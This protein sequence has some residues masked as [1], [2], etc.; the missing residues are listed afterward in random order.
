MG[1]RKLSGAKN[2]LWLGTKGVDVVGDGTTALAGVGYFKVTAKAASGSA[3]G[4]LNIND[5]FYNPESSTL[6]P[7]TGDVV[8]PFTLTKV[9]FVKDIPNSGSKQTFEDTTQIDE[10]KSYQESAIVDLSGSFDGNY[11]VGDTMAEEIL[12]RFFPIIDQ[13][14]A[15][16]TRKPQKIGPVHCF[17]GR[18]EEPQSGESLEMQYLPCIIDSLTFDKPM[19]GVQPLKCNYKAVGSERPSIIRYKAA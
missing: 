9:A 15:T 16:I 10:F 6:T 7:A 14:G 11:A 17:L 3:L 1:I 5:V 2:Y 12:N 13:V 19:E 8:V 4:D 18:N